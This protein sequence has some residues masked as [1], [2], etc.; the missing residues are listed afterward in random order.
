MYVL[1]ITILSIIRPSM[2][3]SNSGFWKYTIVGNTR[4]NMERAVKIFEEAVEKIKIME[5]LNNETD[6]ND[7]EEWTENVNEYKFVS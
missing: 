1:Q 7:P 3:D 4:D 6:I 2:W 5:L